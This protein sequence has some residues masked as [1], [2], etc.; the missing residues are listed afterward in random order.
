MDNFSIYNNL[1]FQVSLGSSILSPSSLLLLLT[2]LWKYQD[3]S[4]C[5]LYLSYILHSTI[6]F[7]PRVVS[8]PLSQ[9]PSHYPYFSFPFETHE[10]V[11]RAYFWLCVQEF[12]LVGSRHYIGYQSSNLVLLYARQV[13]FP[14]YCLEVFINRLCRL[15]SVNSISSCKDWSLV[16]FLLYFFLSH[17]WEVYLVWKYWQM[18]KV[19][20]MKCPIIVN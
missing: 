14:Q 11:H 9:E 15:S 3:L 1:V 20:L 2:I 19:K 10:E 6:T 4:C 13:P 18:I 12:L 7:I 16:L 5:L 17:L 8:L